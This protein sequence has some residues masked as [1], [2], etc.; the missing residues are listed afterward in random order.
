MT[1]DPQRLG[2]YVKARR[3]ELG[4]SQDDV[5]SRGGPS[6]TTLGKIEAGTG[7]LSRIS[8]TK[9]DESLSWT[10]GSARLVLEGGEPVPAEEAAPSVDELESRAR[11]RV[12]LPQALSYDELWRR[13]AELFTESLVLELEYASRRGLEPAEARDELWDVLAMARRARE[14]QPWSPPWEQGS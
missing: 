8:L 9:L 12:P 14:G 10:A 1:S 3:E 11:G 2:R 4:L 13:W 7:G 5:A 6:D